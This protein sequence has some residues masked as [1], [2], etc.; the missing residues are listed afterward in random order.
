M[1]RSINTQHNTQTLYIYTL[2]GF[3][4][5]HR[6]HTYN[7][8]NIPI[9]VLERAQHH[10]VTARRTAF[11]SCVTLTTSCLMLFGSHFARLNGE[12]ELCARS[13][14]SWLISE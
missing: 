8:Y 9:K 11:Q 1:Q 3:S 4:F 12:R 5:V 2:T 6:I 10:Q 13:A 7:T 14:S